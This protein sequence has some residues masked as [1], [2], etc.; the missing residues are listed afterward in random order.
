MAQLPMEHSFLMTTDPTMTETH[1]SPPD[2]IYVQRYPSLSVCLLYFY[3]ANNFVIKLLIK[4]TLHVS[5][6]FCQEP[7]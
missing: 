3:A 7:G 5:F 4:G 2:H 6:L 1:S